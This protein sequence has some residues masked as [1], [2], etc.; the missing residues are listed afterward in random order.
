MLFVKF[1]EI[2]INLRRLQLKSTSLKWTQPHFRA[3]RS[4]AVR[5]QFLKEMFRNVF[6]DARFWKTLGSFPLIPQGVLAHR[7]VQHKSSP[8]DSSVGRRNAG[9]SCRGLLSPVCISRCLEDRLWS[10]L[11]SAACHLPLLPSWY[12]SFNK[13]FF[14]SLCNVSTVQLF[15]DLFSTKKW[16][17]QCG[18]ANMCSEEGNK[19]I[20]DEYLVTRNVSS[21][22][23]RPLYVLLY[24]S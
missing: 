3:P 16:G 10:L 22:G 1:T 9:C 20:V 23:G 17:K 21:C 13:H 6:L 15:W 19:M 2:Y 5:Q 14:V 12:S 11:D 8:S 18:H 7:P 4:S 24:L